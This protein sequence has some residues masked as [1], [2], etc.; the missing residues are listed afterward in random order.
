MSIKVDNLDH[1]GIVAGIIDQIGIVEIIDD[2]LGRHS[3]QKVT[4][5]QAVK[6]VSAFEC[7]GLESKNYHLDSTSLAVPGQYRSQTEELSSPQETSAN[8]EE[9]K[10]PQVIEISH[11]Y[12]RDHR[13]D[14]KQFMVDMLCSGDGGVPLAINLGSGNQN[15]QQ[16]FA[17]RIVAFREQ[18]D[19]EGLFV[20]DCA[21]YSQENLQRMGS[22]QW[23][24]RVPMTI[25]SA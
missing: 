23:L 20:A 24:T 4:T 6:A 12:S 11:G 15:D 13:P 18:W 21:L 22:L 3:Q 14:L 2:N 5:G 25:R 17:K 1:L 19:I 16:V 8:P 7:F 9:E 10:V